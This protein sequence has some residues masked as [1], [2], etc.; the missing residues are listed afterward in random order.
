MPD[1]KKKYEWKKREWVNLEG[2]AYFFYTMALASLQLALFVFMA[3]YFINW[4]MDFRL[5]RAAIL[6][7]PVL[8]IWFLT[9][10]ERVEKE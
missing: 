5:L 6:D 1:A 2:P 3:V 8:T 7:V 4:E 9:T 10:F